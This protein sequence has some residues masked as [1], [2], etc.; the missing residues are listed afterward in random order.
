MIQQ[1]QGLL[2]EPGKGARSSPPRCEHTATQE[3]VVFGESNEW[4]I[5]ATVGTKY[6]MKMVSAIIPGDQFFAF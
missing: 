6:A 3:T 4:L 5:N 1:E 2:M